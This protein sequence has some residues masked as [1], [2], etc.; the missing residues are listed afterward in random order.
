MGDLHLDVVASRLQNEYKVPIELT[1]P[2]VAFRE[3]IK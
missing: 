3:T 1:K 2:K